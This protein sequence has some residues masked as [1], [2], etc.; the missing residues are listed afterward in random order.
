MS[1]N[2][3]DGGN[4]RYII[5]TN[6]EQNI[7]KNVC[8]ERLYKINKGKSLNGISDFNW[9]NNNNPFNC[10]LN[11]FELKKIDASLKNDFDIINNIDILPYLLLNP[12]ITIIN[13]NKAL[14]FQTLLNHLTDKEK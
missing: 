12:N 4:R 1:L 5:I 11:V 10:S 13:N 8:Y 14:F 2:K 7:A 6:N 3:E 9:K